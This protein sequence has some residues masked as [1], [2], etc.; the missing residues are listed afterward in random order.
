MLRGGT[1]VINWLCD[2]PRQA[3]HGGQ[4]Q[5]GGAD[6]EPADSGHVLASGMAPPL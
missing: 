2:V 6:Y 3:P 1:R 4:A 5:L